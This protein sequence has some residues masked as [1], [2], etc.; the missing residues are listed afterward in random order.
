MYLVEFLRAALFRRYIPKNIS[1]RLENARIPVGSIVPA[2][3][4]E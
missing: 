4:N 3:A 2:K 1:Y